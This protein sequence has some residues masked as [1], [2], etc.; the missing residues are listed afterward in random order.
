M[1]TFI[2]GKIF[3]QAIW[4]GHISF[5]LVSVPISLY[6]AS[7]AK[8]LSFTLLHEKDHSRIHYKK[9]CEK[10]DVEINKDDIV[11]GFE[12]QKDQFVIIEDADL[13][14]ANPELTK[15]INIINFVKMSDLQPI[16]FER[17]YYLE[18][19]EAGKKPYELL[20]QALEKAQF[21]GIARTVLRNREYLAA[22]IPYQGILLLQL[23]RYS[24]ELRSVDEIEKPGN[25]RV[26]KKELDLAMEL[27]K[28]LAGDFNYAEY[29]D[30][31]ED[32]VKEVIRRKAEG[33][34]IV[35]LRKGKVPQVKNLMEALERS[36]KE[37]A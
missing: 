30:E 12:I 15:S 28:K 3:M 14:K 31:Y 2:G 33:K 27:I 5:G 8:S 34:K 6:S 37:A 16:W 19:R 7:E 10:E 29:R 1:L 32:Q 24:Q 4:K 13:E 22:L 21:V 36:L 35:S 20:R 25:V 17:P 18:P 23:M 9:Y 11:R 26:E